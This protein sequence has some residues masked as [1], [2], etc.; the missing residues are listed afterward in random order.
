MS[1]KKKKKQNQ[2]SPSTTRPNTGLP[3]PEAF[4][5]QITFDSMEDRI[6]GEEIMQEQEQ[7]KLQE[8][9]KIKKQL[10]SAE[11]DRRM[12]ELRRQLGLES[13]STQRRKGA[14]K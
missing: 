13:S 9:Q 11:V 14:K 1:R 12:E 7:R 5:R 6:R 4:T 2:E 10:E 3:T 8:A